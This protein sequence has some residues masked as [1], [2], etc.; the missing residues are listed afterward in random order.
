MNGI[1]KVLSGLR[2]PTTIGVLLLLAGTG[3]P[4]LTARSAAA[5]QHQTLWV[6][7][8]A[9]L[10][11][12][13]TEI[14][15]RL[16]GQQP[17]LDVRINFAGSQQLA[18]QIEQ[19]AAADVFASAD[20]R[21]MANL[22]DRGFL[23]G[24]S[25]VF[26]RNRLVVIIPKTN[27]ARIR[28]LQDLAHG[29]VKLVLGTDAV[30]VGHYSRTVLQ[31][32]ARDPAFG[33][34]FATRALRNLVSEE[35]NVKSVVAKVRLGEADAG[36]AYRSDVTPAVSRYVRILEIPEAA[37]VVASYPIATLKGAT[38]REAGDAFV[39]LVLSPE[40][41][42]VFEHSGLLPVANAAR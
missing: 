27:P 40:G 34:D 24:D 15:H 19:G 8:A 26:A 18:A 39:A 9:S 20:D 12:A 32:L 10:S 33:A 6:F 22:R 42:G 17:G 14:A 35:E 5:A 29:G 25:K 16:E 3:A 37:N 30:P 7:A 13:F 23:A 31:N 11:D 2:A 28:R 36:M 38:A 4:P 1:M 21:W 41:Q